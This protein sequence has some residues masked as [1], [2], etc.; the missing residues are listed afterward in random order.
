MSFVLHASP[1]IPPIPP[2]FCHLL[3]S[4]LSAPW[5]L[6]RFLRVSFVSVLAPFRA[7]SFRLCFL[8]FC[9]VLLCFG[10]PMPLLWQR[11]K[12]C[13]RTGHTKSLSRL[14]ECRRRNAG[15]QWPGVGG[16]EG[17]GVAMRRRVGLRLQ[18]LFHTIQ[19]NYMI[20]FTAR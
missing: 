19:G 20:L 5:Q 15:R 6:V 7:V 4:Y 10:H 14:V 2:P 8:L 18:P 16:E 12:L 11:V 3:P 17:W 9:F 13:Q 1:P